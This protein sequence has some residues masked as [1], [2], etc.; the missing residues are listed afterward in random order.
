MKRSFMIALLLPIF[1]PGAFSQELLIK[2]KN[3]EAALRT[4]SSN[5][6]AD[7]PFTAAQLADVIYVNVPKEKPITS[8]EGLQGAKKLETIYINGSAVTDLSP[9]KGLPSLTQISIIGGK[10]TDVSTLA[11]L[12]NL[13]YLDLSG[14]AISDLKPLASLKAVSLLGLKNK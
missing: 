11:T 7:Q 5:N 13:K 14:N 8:L 6:K 2:D 12:P 10:I 9:L 3:L 4:Y 1:T